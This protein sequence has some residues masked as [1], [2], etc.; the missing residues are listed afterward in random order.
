MRYGII[1]DTHR[2]D[3]CQTCAMACRLSNGL[4]AGIWWNTVY[5]DGGETIDTAR[6]TYPNDL[7]LQHYPVACQHCQNPACVEVCPTGA[8]YIDES[9]G[10]VQV[11]N[12]ECI[13][14]KACMSACP[15]HVRSYVDGE[16]V[17]ATDFMTGYV[18][19]PAHVAGTVE[20]CTMCANLVSQGERPTCVKACT[21]YA[22]TFGD[23]DDPNSEVSK[24]LASRE[25]IQLLPE[26]GTNPSI[27]YLK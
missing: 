6:G 9:N 17:Y 14:C 13:G 27:Y 20:K 21:G 22:R 10:T 4:P 23:L 19:A 7:T 3:G 5:T 2:C 12:E 15:Y 24:L 18:D 16:P 11:N 1:I 26:Q 8:S 25:H